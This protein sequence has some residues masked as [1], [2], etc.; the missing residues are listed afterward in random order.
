MKIVIVICF[1][2]II[3][4]I[5]AK[6]LG[7]MIKHRDHKRAKEFKECSATGITTPII[8]SNGWRCWAATGAF[9]KSSTGRTSTEQQVIDEFVGLGGVLATGDR[10][11]GLPY[12]D[13]NFGHYMAVTGTHEV[14][15][16]LTVEGLCRDLAHGPLIQFYRT[17][18]T[19]SHVVLITRTQ[20]S[21]E[22]DTM[23]GFIDPSNGNEQ[24][25]T[26]NEFRNEYSEAVIGKLF[27]KA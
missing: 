10:Q 9:F 3:T 24:I 12:T 13:A 15:E 7:K 23:V 14:L 4:V 11:D 8:Q 16:T 2:I 17:G 26:V 20:G 27:R 22:S 19:S 21:D 6:S 18:D 25:K 5:D 1:L